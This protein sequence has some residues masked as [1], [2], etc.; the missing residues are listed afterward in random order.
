MKTGIALSLIGLASLVAQPAAAQD[1]TLKLHHFNPP[2]TTM[3]RKFILPWVEMVKKKTGGRIKIDVYPSLQL[4]G[5]PQ[6]LLD[7]VRDGVVDITWTITGYTPGRFPSLEVFELPFVHQSIA[8]SNQALFEMQKTYLK[9]ELKDYKVLVLHVHAGNVLITK[10][11]PIRT[12]ADFKGMKIRTPNQSGSWFL[13]AVGA[14][15]IGTPI[16]AVAQ[17]LSR[18]VI[19][20]AALPFEIIAPFKLHELTKYATELEGGKRFQTTVFILAMNKAKYES[21]PPDLKKMFDEATGETLVKL[22]TEVWEAAE[23]PGIAAAKKRGN[24]F[25]TMSAAEVA[26]MKTLA[27]PAI[28]RWIAAMKERGIDGAKLL[29]VARETIKKYEK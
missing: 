11:K 13:E 21:L 29:Q 24:V 28:A 9:D 19:D 16:T 7:Q 26:K 27:Q 12:V 14:S 18:G 8:S 22:A 1:V 6:Q 17:L 10:N 5:K 2:T 3:H 23:A 15:P 20:G 25:I 4:G